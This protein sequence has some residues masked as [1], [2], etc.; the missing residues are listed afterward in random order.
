MVLRPNLDILL[1]KLYE[2]KS[3]ILILYYAQQQEI[4]G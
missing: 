1:E 2:L 3:K 4:I